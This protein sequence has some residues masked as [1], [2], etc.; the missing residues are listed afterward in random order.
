[1]STSLTDEQLEQLLERL[2]DLA[3]TQKSAP[4]RSDLERVEDK[5]SQLRE[6]MRED[7]ARLRTQVKADI[8]DLQNSITSTQM[9]LST[10]QG[11]IGMILVGVGALIGSAASAALNWFMGRG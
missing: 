5:V 3:E 8:G 10:W 7:M 2:A 9:D 11:R 1:M 4:S 6:D